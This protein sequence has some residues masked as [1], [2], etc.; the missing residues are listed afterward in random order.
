MNRIFEN[1]I[2]KVNEAYPSI[3]TK[4]DVIILINDLKFAAERE[5]ADTSTLNQDAIDKIR[6]SLIE[7]V[8]NLSF[9][10]FVELELG[11]HNQIEINFDDHGLAKDIE[12]CFDTAVDEVT[13]KD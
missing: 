2:V 4:D 1:A 6:E 7:G 13:A 11:Y 10:D 5:L 3:F 12:Q 9:P 8:R